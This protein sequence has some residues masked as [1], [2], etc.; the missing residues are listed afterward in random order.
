MAT[1]TGTFFAN[2]SLDCPDIPGDGWACID[3]SQLAVPPATSFGFVAVALLSVTQT[4]CCD[5]IGPGWT[6]TFTYDDADLQ[7]GVV[8]TS[9]NVHTI[10]CANCLEDF[11]TFIA[12]GDSLAVADTNS[13]DLTLAAGTLSADVVIDP[14]AGNQLSVSGAGLFVP[15]SAGGACVNSVTTAAFNAL[16]LANGLEPGCT[17]II[18]DHS[19]NRVPVNTQV[20]VTALSVDQVTSAC[21]VITSYDTKPWRGTYNQATNELV[22]LWDNQGNYAS[23]G[24]PG[25]F[26][27]YSCVDDFDWGN[28]TITNCKLVQGE[29]DLDYGIATAIIDGVEILSNGSLEM[30]GYTGTYLQNIRIEH[31]GTL[32]ITDSNLELEEVLITNQGTIASRSTLTFGGSS[33]SFIFN[34]VVDSST[35]SAPIAN[36]ALYMESSNL[37]GLSGIYFS[38]EGY[39]SV[40]ATTLANQSEIRVTGTVPT[41][42]TSGPE[43]FACSLSNGSKIEFLGVT[44][45]TAVSIQQST[46]MSFSTLNLTSITEASVSPYRQLTLATNAVVNLEGDGIV[47]YLQVEQAT[48]N[49]DG[50]D[51]QDVYCRGAGTKTCTANNT[52]TGKDYF[53]DNIV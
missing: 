6:Y 15:A 29:W 39:L 25:T 49:P 31:F 24:D 11:I 44:T 7:P 42:G 26:G 18:T 19:Q 50:F 48:F 16:V 22:E 10:F 36:T 40:V 32:D 53:N 5:A 17:Y 43:I 1:K 37:T 13:V 41:G 14:D 51:I 23:N 34:C 27:P 35:V 8:L 52:G 3:A 47:Y 33:Q 20:I 30:S 2:C 28:P 21:S 4:S 46:L 38:D 12:G 9:R 45:A